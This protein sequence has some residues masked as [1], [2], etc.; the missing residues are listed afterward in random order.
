[1]TTSELY[2]LPSD[3]WT[4]IAVVDMG[5]LIPSIGYRACCGRC[6]YVTSEI[7]GAYKLAWDDAMAHHERNQGMRLFPDPQSV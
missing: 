3:H 7:R 4:W 2:S 6:G 1:M 5:H